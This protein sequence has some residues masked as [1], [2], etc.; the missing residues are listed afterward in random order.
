MDY[1]MDFDFSKSFTENF[2]ELMSGVPRCA[3]INKNSEN[4]EYT[5]ISAN[6]KNCYMIIESANNEDCYY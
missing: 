4:S 1:G 5:N 2:I 6:N 3:I